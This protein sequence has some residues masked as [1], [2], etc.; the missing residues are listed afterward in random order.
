VD[1]AK[2]LRRPENHV[3]IYR[4]R[5]T[6]LRLLKIC[7]AALALSL[8]G[9]ATQQANVADSSPVA[10]LMKGDA[11]RGRDVIMGRDGNCLLC[12]A[13]P[14]TGARFMGNLGPPLSG[15]GARLDSA[16]LK[17]RIVDPL[18]F[19]PDSIMPAY[20]RTEGLTHVG[21]VYRDKPILTGQQI[22]DIVAYLAALR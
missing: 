12:H 17:L 8:A 2:Y 6:A 15:I 1:P 20:G 3:V 5:I 18:R 22:D 14:E 4:S 13:V 11:S 10:G 9:C 21:K 19:N 7:F 16:Q